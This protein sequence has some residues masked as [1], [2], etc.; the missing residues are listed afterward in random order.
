MATLIF[1][2]PLNYLNTED[3]KN[4]SN[5]KEFKYNKSWHQKSKTRIEVI[6]KNKSK[7]EQ[8]SQFVKNIR[9]EADLIVEAS[10]LGLDF[11]VSPG[12]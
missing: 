6:S 12:R 11:S 4:R 8:P 9:V 2:S 5:S 10:L 3:N 7:S 1:F